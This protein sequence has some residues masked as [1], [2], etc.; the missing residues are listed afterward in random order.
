MRLASSHALA[1]LLLFAVAPA[2]GAEKGWWHFRV[3][4][5]TKVRWTTV[6]PGD[7]SSHWVITRLKE[8]VPDGV[9]FE[10]RNSF[11]QRLED[12]LGGL[13]CC[14]GPPARSDSLVRQDVLIVDGRP[15]HC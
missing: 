6:T 7:T 11:G 9:W 13:G 2:V 10:H 12:G 15:V 1:V 3:G 14:G 4:S 8:N 5:W